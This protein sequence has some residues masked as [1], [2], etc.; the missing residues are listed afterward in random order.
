MT[1]V[2]VIDALAENPRPSGAAKLKGTDFMRI[3]VR[4]YRVVYEVRDDVLLVLVVRV[5]H[6]RG[7]YRGLVPVRH[8]AASTRTIVKVGRG[9][10]AA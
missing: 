5:E 3:R 7:A 4:D 6:R 1:I 2:Q 10:L 8:P 9:P